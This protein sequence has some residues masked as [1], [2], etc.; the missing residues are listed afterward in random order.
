M[1]K[2]AAG[3]R[4][5]QAALAHPSGRVRHSYKSLKLTDSTCRGCAGRFQQI[6]A[7]ATV[8][9]PPWSTTTDPSGALFKSSNMPSKSRP[10]VSGSKYLHTRWGGKRFRLS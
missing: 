1:H 4:E 7:A 3:G 8:R 2:V 5:L 6:S 10:T 9:G